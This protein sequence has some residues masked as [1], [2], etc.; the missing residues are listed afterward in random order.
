M[1][2]AINSGRIFSKFDFLTVYFR[3]LIP[4][5]P[6]FNSVEFSFFTPVP[7][8]VYELGTFMK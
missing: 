4:D 1:N 5:M 2:T 7:T 3:F 8:H 6:F